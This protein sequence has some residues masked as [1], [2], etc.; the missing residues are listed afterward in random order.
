MAKLNINGDYWGVYSLVDQSNND[1]IDAVSSHDGDRWRAPN[2]AGGGGGG[3]RPGGGFGGGGAGGFVAP[4]SH[5][6]WAQQ[7]LVTGT[8]TN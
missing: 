5:T 4:F 3:P 7:L 1:L 2:I 8:T 6:I